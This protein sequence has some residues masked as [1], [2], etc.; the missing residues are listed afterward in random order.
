M[1]NLQWSAVPY[2]GLETNIEVTE[3]GRVRH[4]KVDWLNYTTSAKLGEVNFEKLNLDSNGY[5]RTTIQIKENK[6]KTV[7]V[8]QLVAAAFLGY[9]FNG[10]KLVVD[11]IDSNPLNN[12]LLN[13]RIIT[14]RENVNKELIIKK[15][16]PAGVCW[17][18]RDKVFRSSI[19]IN[20]KTIIL[21]YFKTP[22]EASQA[23]QNK[24]NE[25]N[26]RS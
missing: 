12:N 7:R 25:I 24:L 4:I 13:L 3:C 1:E 18:K 19:K 5:K 22:E 6:P 20:M 17:L 11:H 8:H 10:N 26:N 21:G 15:G 2:N 14:Q 9:Q 23:Y 16:L